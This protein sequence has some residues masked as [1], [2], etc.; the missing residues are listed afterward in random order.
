MKPRAGAQAL[1]LAPRNID[2]QC[3]FALFLRMQGKEVE[4]KSLYSEAASV[5]PD[6]PRVRALATLLSVG[7]VIQTGAEAKARELR[8]EQTT[9]SK[10][11]RQQ[12]AYV[13]VIRGERVMEA[14]RQCP[15]A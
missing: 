2:M 15:L 9:N 13:F 11:M 4:A 6:H 7:T 14:V 3:Q 5:A 1:E 12:V 10:M 8:R